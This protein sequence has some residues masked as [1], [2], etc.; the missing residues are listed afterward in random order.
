MYVP[1]VFCLSNASYKFLKTSQVIHIFFQFGNLGNFCKKVSF[2]V[3]SI[4]SNLHI[5][6]C[7]DLRKS[8][9]EMKFPENNTIKTNIA[10]V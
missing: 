10:D 5:Y 3:V 8:S 7:T 2:K 6:Q 1:G 9:T 4:G